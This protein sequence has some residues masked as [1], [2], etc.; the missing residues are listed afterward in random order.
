MYFCSIGNFQQ[1]MPQSKKLSPEEILKQHEL[2]ATPQRIDVLSAFLKK[3]QVLS[4]SE[5]NKILGKGFDRITLYRTL[6]A[7]EEHGLIHK[8]PD[9][10]GNINYAICKHDSIHHSHDDNHIHFQCMKCN[11]TVCLDELEIPA[12]RVPKKYNPVKYNFL[13]EGVCE[14]CEVKGKKLKR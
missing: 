1:S 11:L 12:I 3:N 14:D 10:T 5:I 6:N 2:K 4:L 7:F 8:I 9:S 13:I